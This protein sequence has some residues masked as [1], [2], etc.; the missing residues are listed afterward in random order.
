M[1]WYIHIFV[2]KR[3]IYLSYIGVKVA[4]MKFFKKVT[5]PDFQVRNF[6][7]IKTHKSRLFSLTIKQHKCIKPNNLVLFFS[8]EWARFQEF[9]TK[10]ITDVCNNL[11]RWQ[12][13]Y[14]TAS[15]G[16][17]D[18]FLLCKVVEHES[19]ISSGLPTVRILIGRSLSALATWWLIS[20]LSALATAQHQYQRYY[21]EK[22]QGITSQFGC[23]CFR[24]RCPIVLPTSLYANLPDKTVQLHILLK[25]GIEGRGG[26][27]LSWQ[28]HPPPLLLLHTN[29]TPPLTIQHG[30][31]EPFKCLPS[32][33]M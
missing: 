5:Q 22:P 19:S 30:R 13:F 27:G 28:G 29:P 4:D 14:T 23:V 6:T 25:T 3:S 7:H 20:L 8:I 33:P 16:D 9:L 2:W 21:E 32:G 15:R 26:R 10:V 11:H 18:K 31:G 24:P 17:R 1:Y 12:I